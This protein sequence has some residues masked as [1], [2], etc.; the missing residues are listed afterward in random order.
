M[1]KKDIPWMLDEAR[2]YHNYLED[3]K[4]ALKICEEILKKDPCNRDALLIKAGSLSCI[5]KEKE[6]YLLIIEIM[7]K[8]PEHWEAYY[9]MGLLLFNTN[10]EKAMKNFNKSIALEPKF[11]NN[12]CAAQLAYFMQFSDYKKYLACAKKIDPPRYANYMKNCWE[13]EIC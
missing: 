13:W 6:S 11:D 8:W 1:N 3:E 10:E 9:L 7:N 2:Y 4:K 5:C 12:I